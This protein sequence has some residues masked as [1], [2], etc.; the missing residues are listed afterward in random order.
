MAR[1]N[2]VYLFLLFYFWL[3]GDEKKK[4][5]GRKRREER[6]REKKK[7]EAQAPCNCKAEEARMRGVEFRAG[8]LI[9]LHLLICRYVD[10]VCMQGCM[11]GEQPLD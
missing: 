8:R 1:C 11:T 6:R 4:R 10:M 9:C 2:S 3:Q 5:D 7:R